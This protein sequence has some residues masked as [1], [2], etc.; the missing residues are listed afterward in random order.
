MIDNEFEPVKQ[1]LDWTAFAFQNDEVQAAQV[2]IDDERAPEFQ[3]VIQAWSA[4]VLQDS[5][6]AREPCFD[7]EVHY[8]PAVTI[9]WVSICIKLWLADEL[10]FDRVNIPCTTLYSDGF[11]LVLADDGFSI[12]L[13][14]DG[15]SLDLSD[16]RCDC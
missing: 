12:D 3:C 1:R 9:G 2:V 8:I 6:Q 14:D 11:T 10:W 5:E 4:I 16:V 15:R 7:D 13:T